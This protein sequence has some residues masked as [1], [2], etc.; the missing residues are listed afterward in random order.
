M[1]TRRL[2]FDPRMTPP[3]L[4]PWLASWLNRT[5]RPSAGGAPAAADPGGSLVVP[6]AGVKAGLIDYLEIYTPAGRQRSP[7]TG[8]KT[9][10][11]A[12]GQVGPGIAL[13]KATSP[14]LYVTLR[15]PP[16]ASPAGMKMGGRDRKRTAAAPS[17]RS[18]EAEKP[19]HT[20]V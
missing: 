11:G 1:I 8:P 14:C 10:F 2:Y 5:G 4:L 13:A 16:V 3:D 19:A 12:G 7:N 9:S 17:K 18:F 15:L 6:G 20:V